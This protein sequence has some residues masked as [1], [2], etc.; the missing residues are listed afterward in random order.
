MKQLKQRAKLDTVD[1]YFNSHQLCKS[2]ESI[3]VVD[4]AQLAS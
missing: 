2:V 4:V 1:H 3:A